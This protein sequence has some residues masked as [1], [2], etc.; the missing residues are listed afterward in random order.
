MDELNHVTRAEIFDG[1]VGNVVEGADLD[2][3]VAVVAV[4]CNV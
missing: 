2:C 4:E 3:V 1:E